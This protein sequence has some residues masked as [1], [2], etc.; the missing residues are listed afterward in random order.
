MP[1]ILFNGK[2]YNDINDMPA[3]EREAFEQMSQIFVDANGNG[4]PDFLEGDI[5][6]N[7]VTAHSTQT[8]INVNGKTYHSYNELPPE[9]REHVDGAFKMLSNM[10]FL[11][12]LPDSQTPPASFDSQVKSKPIPEQQPSSAIEEEHGTGTFTL[13]IGGV[14]LCFAILVV[15]IGV[16]YMM[17]R[18]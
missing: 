16:F 4:I 10:G 2:T 9:M 6:K 7:V 15:T 5:V 11:D 17:N 12:G 8:N 14:V 1:T 18:P 3:D 13:V